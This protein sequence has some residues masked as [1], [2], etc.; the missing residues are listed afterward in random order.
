MSHVDTYTLEKRKDEGI[1]YTP[2]FL[3]LYLARKIIYYLNLD[4]YNEK[5]LNI[6]DPACG[7]SALLHNFLRMTEG[8]NLDQ[9]NIYGIDKDINAIISST[10]SFST[11]FE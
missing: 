6:I 11:V 2:E 3:S 5:Q 9:L 8:T 4:G 7:D 1:Y 10:N